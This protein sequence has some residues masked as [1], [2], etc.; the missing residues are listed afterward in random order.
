MS[1]VPTCECGD[2]ETIK[3]F[4]IECPR[5]RQVQDDMLAI[6]RA[7]VGDVPVTVKLL[8]KGEEFL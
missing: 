4:L 5:Y 2:V 3:H 1:D 8:L 6:I 7:R